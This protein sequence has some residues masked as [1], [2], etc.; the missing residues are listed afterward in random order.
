M[1]TQITFAEC[2]C[3]IPPEVASGE[4]YIR[5]DL[6]HLRKNHPAPTNGEIAS[7]ERHIIDLARIVGAEQGEPREGTP[8]AKVVLNSVKSSHGFTCSAH[9]RHDEGEAQWNVWIDDKWAGECRYCLPGMIERG[10][11]VLDRRTAHE[12]L[13]YLLSGP[14]GAE[15]YLDYFGDERYAARDW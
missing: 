12:V 11:V 7:R 1:T 2:G 4:V 13:A 5:P 15:E 3:P 14:K 10:E 8:T 6:W 9:G